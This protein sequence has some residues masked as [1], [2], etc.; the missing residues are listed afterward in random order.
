[1]IGVMKVMGV[2]RCVLIDE[3]RELGISWLGRKPLRGSSKV[4]FWV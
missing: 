3:S 4:G 1:M 2:G